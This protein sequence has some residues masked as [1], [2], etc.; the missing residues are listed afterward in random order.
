MT[1][2]CKLHM[3][4]H[5]AFLLLARNMG[6]GEGQKKAGALGAPSLLLQQHQ[7][8]HNDNRDDA[9]C[10]GKEEFNCNKHLAQCN[11]G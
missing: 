9:G 3:G 11:N 7:F 8:S 1:R 6:G 2:H 5:G 4:S 10:S